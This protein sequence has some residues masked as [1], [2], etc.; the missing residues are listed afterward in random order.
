MKTTH[1]HTLGLFRLV[2]DFKWS[3]DRHSCTLAQHKDWK[4][5]GGGKQN[6]KPWQEED[7]HDADFTIMDFWEDL[8]NFNKSSG[9]QIRRKFD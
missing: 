7:V 8:R 4:R 2:L 1:T 5:F 9:I 3:F 6:P